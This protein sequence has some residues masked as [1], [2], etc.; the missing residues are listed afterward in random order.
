[1]K[2]S[3]PLVQENVPA[4]VEVLT[5]VSLLNQKKTLKMVEFGLKHATITLDMK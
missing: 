5:K 1:M 2:Y 3:H 4:H